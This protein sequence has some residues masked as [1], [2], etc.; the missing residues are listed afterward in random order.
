MALVRFLVD[1]SLPK[2]LV[3]AVLHRNAAIDIL[4]VGQSGA[5]PLEATDEVIVLY[6]ERYQRLLLDI[7][8]TVR[9][10]MAPARQSQPRRAGLPSLDYS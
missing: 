5:R 1:E 3:I 8:P 9:D 6:A 4:R 2:C 10:W 7:T